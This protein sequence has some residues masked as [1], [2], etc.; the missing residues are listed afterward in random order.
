[1]KLNHQDKTELRISAE[2]I[3]SDVKKGNRIHIGKEILEELLFDTIVY[4]K[5]EKKT[6]KLP[7]WS[8]FFRKN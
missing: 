7:V 3:L 6:L 5:K 4:N 8:G 1:M 2:T